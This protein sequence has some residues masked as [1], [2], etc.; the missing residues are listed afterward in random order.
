MSTVIIA[1]II[2]T[3]VV[4]ICLLL[5]FINSRHRRK[6]ANEL[7]A[8]FQNEV[9]ENNL[10][11]SKWDLAGKLIIGLEVDKKTIFAFQKHLGQ[12]KS[13]LVDLSEVNNCLKK[14]I[15]SSKIPGSEN[16]EGYERQVEHISLQFEFIDERPPVMITFYHPVNNHL[17]EMAEMEQKTTDWERLVKSIIHPN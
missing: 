9:K 16:K 8:H 12:F 3:F 7:I 2:V 11:I 6:A 1:L 5:V 13:Y 17:L 10:L 4:V 15:Y 14:K